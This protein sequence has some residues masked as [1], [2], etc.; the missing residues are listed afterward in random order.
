MVKDTRKTNEELLSKEIKQ[1]NTELKDG[2]FIFKDGVTIHDFAKSI[3]VS[4]TEIITYFFKQGKMLNIN[5]ILN[6]DHVTELCIEYNIDFQKETQVDASNVMDMINIEDDEDELEEKPPVVTIMGHVDHGKTTLIDKIRKS[7]I[8][9]S[10]AGGITQHTGSYQIEHD[11]KKITFIDTPGHEAFT[12]M[13]ARGAKVTDIVIL[14]VAADDGVM[15]QT[16]EAIDHAKIAKV[17]II[18]FVNKMDKHGVDPEKV[19]TELSKYDVVAEEWGGDVQF[20]YGSALQGDG[21][22]DLFSAISLQAEM[23][24]LKANPNRMAIGTVVEARVDPKKGPLATIIVKTGTLYMRDFIV[25]GSNY[26]KIKSMINSRYESIKTAGPATPV[27]I[28]GLNYTPEAGSKFFA[29]KDEKFAKKLAEEKKN[30]DKDWELKTKK[31]FEVKDGVKVLNIV[32]KSDVQGTA[33]AVKHALVKLENEEAVVNV[34]R[35]SVGVVTKSDILLANAAQASIYTF[36]LKVSDDI[37][38]FAKEQGVHIRLYSII[39]QMIE[40]VELLLKGL[41]APKYEEQDTGRAQIL[42]VI[43]ASNKGNIAGCRLEDGYVISQSK[44]RVM[45]GGKMI[46]EGHLDSLQRGPDAA[47]KVE[48]GK[49]FGCHIHKFEDIKEGDILE[50]FAD[51]EVK[52]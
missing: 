48:N 40:D 46:H 38:A 31:A 1:V 14:V 26:G 5:H 49:D 4:P 33:Q 18:V 20:V 11:D 45:R 42:K 6:E 39:Y 50:F 12:S 19:K 10:E 36:N 24:Q 41:K 15:P 35:A 2:V 27:L 47:K 32:V 51:V 52:E 13:R 21:I 3:K 28:M 37:K 8:T 17:P 16:K 22:D 25:A 34:V 44:V 43:Y 29:F 23:L 7:N 30:R 9:S